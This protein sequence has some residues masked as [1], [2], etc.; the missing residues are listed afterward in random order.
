MKKHVLLSI[1][2]FISIFVNSQALNTVDSLLKLMRGQKDTAIT[3]TL[4]KVGDFYKIKGMR[5]SAVYY[6][7]QALKQAQK[8][9]DEGQICK[10]YLAIANNIMHLNKFEEAIEIFFKVI[11]IAE[12]KGLSQHVGYA[13]LDIGIIYEYQGRFKDALK[14]LY[15]SEHEFDKVKDSAGLLSLYPALLTT[16]ASNGDT[17]KALTYFKKGVD[18]L[19]KYGLSK[20]ISETDKESLPHLRMALVFNAVNNMSKDEDLKM[21]L[22]QVKLLEPGIR[23]GNNEFQK[24]QVYTLY[25]ITSLKLRQYENAQKYATEAIKYIR[26]ESGNYTEVMA[27]HKII[28]ESSASLGQYNKAYEAIITYNQYHDS[29]YKI[30]S[31]EAIHSVEAK[32]ETAKK[33]EQ[34]K[35]LNKEKRGQ[36]I[37]VIVVITGLLIAIGFLVFVLRAKRLEKKLFVKEKE[38]QKKELE[39]KMAELEQTALRAQMNPHF[40]FNCLNSVQRFIIGNDAEGANEYLSTF[41]NLIRQTLENSGKK[42]IPLKDELLYLETYIKMEQLRSNNKFDYDISIGAEVDQ[43]ETYIPNMIVQPYVEN[44]IHHGMLHTNNKKGF[45]KLDISQGNKLN[46]T[47][48]DNGAGINNKNIIQTDRD[49]HHSMG[50]AITEK[51]IAMYNSLHDDKI[52]LEVLDKA[53]T[54]SLES[55]TSVILKFPLNN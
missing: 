14:F 49:T 46:F 41:A 44:S 34:I 2:S 50:G 20:K 45:I 31:L 6:Y 39:Q 47:I 55:G 26:P 4:F 43:T 23:D 33:E 32:Y 24:F 16:V 13:K 21:A 48:D 19:D 51:R 38:I 40:I 52:E 15:E 7:T 8:N 17:L 37:L 28:A 53:D 27:L 12:K 25:A 36:K 54:G 29:V 35:T 18:L 5:D 22:E 1:F 10:A 42:L 30:T 9:N 3:N 11:P